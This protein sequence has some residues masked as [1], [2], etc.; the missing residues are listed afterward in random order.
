MKLAILILSILLFHEVNAQ[1]K[2]YV[3]SPCNRSCDSKVYTQPG[4]C[5]ECHM[6]LVEKSALNFP[7]LSV[8]EF[9]ARIAANSNAVLLDVRSASEFNGSALFRGTYG[10]FKNA[11]NINIDDLEDRLDEIETYKDREILVYCSHSVRSPRAAM[12]LNQHGY[13]NVKN[14]AGGVSTIRV[15]ANDCLKKNFVVHD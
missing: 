11:I 3:C 6:A 14:L 5:P 15:G 4:A 8:E 9:C 12:I 2:E 1:T 7:N 10:H 13:K